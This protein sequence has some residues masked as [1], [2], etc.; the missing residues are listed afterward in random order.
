MARCQGHTPPT[1]IYDQKLA[2][3]M[4]GQTFCAPG[5]ESA[6]SGS[7]PWGTPPDSLELTSLRGLSGK[8]RGACPQMM[9]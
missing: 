1:Q 7:P 9:E 2:S 6:P 8:D 4:P 3:A 5:R